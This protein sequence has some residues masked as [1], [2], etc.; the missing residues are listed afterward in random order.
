MTLEEVK[1]SMREA[2]V[3]LAVVFPFPSTALSRPSTIDWVAEVA[4]ADGS[5]VPFYY[6]LD[7]L[8]PPR[9][10]RFRGVKWH[11]VRGV[12][13]WRSNYEVLRDSRLDEFAGA[14]SRLRIPVIFEEELEFTEEFVE[15]YPEV[16]LV[17]PHVGMLGGRP[18]DFIRRFKECE[19]V[20][21]DTSLAPPSVVAEALEAVGPGRVLFGSD[22]PFGHMY[23]ELRKV[24]GLGL[25]EAN[26]EAVLGGNAIRLL[27]LEPR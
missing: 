7:D 22:V 15:R 2:G 3:D 18:S 12:S 4:L 26:E 24:R 23:S 6:V 16:V 19:N 5:L 20:H 14:V 21:F 17:I 13:D 8:E 10:P 1:E 25:S 27:R 11:W 9:D